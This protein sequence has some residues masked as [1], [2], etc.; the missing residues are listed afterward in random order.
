MRSR[1]R[2]R[3]HGS[4]RGRRDF[5]ASYSIDCDVQIIFVIAAPT[6]DE[7]VTI[8]NFPIWEVDLSIW[9]IVDLRAITA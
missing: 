4:V 9:S 8:N 1:V 3:T 6:E 5:P 7:A 2:T